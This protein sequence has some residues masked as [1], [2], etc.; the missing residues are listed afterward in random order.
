MPKQEIKNHPYFKE[1]K[2]QNYD[3]YKRSG[4]IAKEI[5]V[6]MG[7]IEGTFLQNGSH[8]VCLNFWLQE[9]L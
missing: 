1:D 8:T 2:S 4:R 9:Y 3:G 5:K 6:E 7:M